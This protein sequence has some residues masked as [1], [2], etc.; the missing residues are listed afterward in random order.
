VSLGTVVVD[1][2][3]LLIQRIELREGKMYF[4][5]S[6]SGPCTLPGRGGMVRVHG[7]DGSLIL[8]APWLSTAG[9]LAAEEDHSITV[10]V[11]VGFSGP[12]ADASCA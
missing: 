2:L 12:L 3:I 5:A 4:V 11:P 6:C 9:P 7:H 8:T 10:Y 1:E